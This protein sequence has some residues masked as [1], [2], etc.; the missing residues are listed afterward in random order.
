MNKPISA[1]HK[2]ILNYIYA[3]LSAIN[4]VTLRV[5]QN[6]E[7]TLV[8]YQAGWRVGG[9]GF[10]RFC[11]DGL[12]ELYNQTG[13]PSNH[14]HSLHGLELVDAMLGV[15]LADLL[16]RLVL[17]ATLGDVLLVQQVVAGDARLV[18]RVGQLGFQRL[19]KGEYN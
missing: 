4:R 6:D 11:R 16:E 2:P 18:L 10:G 1:T 7:T 13:A 8:W 17:V 5:T 15:A 12:S 14:L 3:H 9:G 19:E